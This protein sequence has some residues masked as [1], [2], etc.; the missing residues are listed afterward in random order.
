[1]A[2]IQ[3][4]SDQVQQL[5]RQATSQVV[6]SEVNGDDD[7]TTSA[8]GSISCMDALKDALGTKEVGA[9]TESSDGSEGFFVEISE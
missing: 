2:K 7:D 6:A 3:S 8:T 4:L 9:P 1:M 5:E